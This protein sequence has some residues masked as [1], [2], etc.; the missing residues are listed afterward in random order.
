[1]RIELPSTSESTLFSLCTHERIMPDFREWSVHSTELTRA[2]AHTCIIQISFPFSRI[3]R[4]ARVAGP[5]QVGT[6][7]AR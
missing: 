5:R 2:R 7:R 6:E 4:V 1:M 3:G